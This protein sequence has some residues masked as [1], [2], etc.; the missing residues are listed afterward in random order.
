MQII[1]SYANA[2]L[3]AKGTS[4]STGTIAW[5]PPSLPEDVNA[6]DEIRISG[7]WMWNGRGSINRVT[8]NRTNTTTGVYFDIP[9]SLDVGSSLSISC[10]GN[11]N[12]TGSSFS[13]SNLV[14]KYY[15]TE[16]PK[17]VNKVV[18]GDNILIDLTPDT[19]DESQVESGYTVHNMKGKQI[20]GTIDITSYYSGSSEPT[21]DI[22]KDGDLYFK[23][24]VYNNV[25][26]KDLYMDSFDS[27]NSSGY[28]LSSGSVN[29]CCGHPYTETK[30][31][32]IFV[33]KEAAYS[34]FVLFYNFNIPRLPKNATNISI[35][36]KTKCYWSYYQ[37]TD[38]LVEPH[39]QLYNGISKPKGTPTINV[40]RE[41]A[42]SDTFEIDGGTWTK[43]EIKDCRIRFYAKRGQEDASKISALWMYGTTLYVSFKT[44]DDPKTKTI[45]TNA[46]IE[47][48]NDNNFEN[49][50]NF[51]GTDP[52]NDKS[53]TIRH[54]TEYPEQFIKC[55]F[56]NPRL[57][58]DAIIKS[59]Y[60]DLLARMGTTK[61][62]S[63]IGD[64]RIDQYAPNSFYVQFYLGKSAITEEILIYERSVGNVNKDGRYLIELKK[65]NNY[66][67][68]DLSNISVRFKCVTNSI[69]DYSYYNKLYFG[70]KIDI[71][72][73][74]DSV[75]HNV[76]TPVSLNKDAVVGE[77][78]TNS[79]YW[80]SQIGSY[81][82]KMILGRSV[83]NINEYNN[84]CSVCTIE[85][86][87]G[88]DLLNIAYAFDFSSVPSDAEIT[89]IYARINACWEYNSDVP[90]DPIYERFGLCKGSSA[91][92]VTEGLSIKTGYTNNT[93]KT[94]ETKKQYLE[95]IKTVDDLYN[96]LFYIR[97]EGTYGDGY[98]VWASIKALDIVLSYYSPSAS[99]ESGSNATPTSNVIKLKSNGTWI[100]TEKAYSKE[101]GV[102]TERTDLENLLNPNTN[103]V[104]K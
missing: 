7:T 2:S 31:Q 5:T 40:R 73:Y 9:L 94:F 21:S 33:F 14:V 96:V 30:D 101:S 83:D 29:T 62:L 47:I 32:T 85:H 86:R 99:S 67:I 78:I 16:P 58:S 48:T 88:Y 81:G 66:E 95:Y 22:G 80:G 42:D 19:V 34:E 10:V 35:R 20:E 12:A 98:E 54:N 50:H 104:K 69:G 74:S 97:A 39:V 61:D 45:K 4:T 17:E 91:I 24:P 11:K 6:W 77:Y 15:Y 51:I 90:D 36:C 63:Y 28:E 89:E 26:L 59:V 60:C 25:D 3:T 18:Y 8:I 82:P 38:D 70:I 41:Y 27:T 79:S 46:F 13:W 53:I 93:T 57:P 64:S 84:A 102:W 52:S 87:S 68:S 44:P 56:D 75:E 1:V 55:S 100:D 49:T 37:N 71:E 76:F 72:Y 23:M 92:Y 43:D 65:L 103:Y